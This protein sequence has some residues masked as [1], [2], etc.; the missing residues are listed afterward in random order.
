MEM[1]AIRQ[2]REKLADSINMTLKDGVVFGISRDEK[3]IAAIVPFKAGQ[4]VEDVSKINSVSGL[5]EC[6]EGA[7]DT[8]DN[9]L[10]S[11]PVINVLKNFIHQYRTTDNS[12]VIINCDNNIIGDSNEMK[13]IFF[14]SDIAIGQ[15]SIMRVNGKYIINSSINTKNPAKSVEIILH[16][17]MKSIITDIKGQNI[18]VTNGAETEEEISLELT[19][20]KIE[21]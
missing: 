20:I 21:H 16:P 6:L 13:N 5:I 9:A 18:F 12:F 14:K 8:H 19:K 10:I 11:P 15:I 1:I 4:F 17:T 2:L 7:K 3:P